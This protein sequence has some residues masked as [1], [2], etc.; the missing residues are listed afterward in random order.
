MCLYFCGLVV[1]HQGD[2]VCMRVICFGPA[3][4][5]D[6]FRKEQYAG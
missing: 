3:V 6:P 2:F 5:F 4:Y 1:L